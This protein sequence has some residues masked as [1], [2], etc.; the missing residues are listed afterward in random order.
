VTPLVRAKGGELGVRAAPFKGVQTSLALWRL[1]LDSELVFA[2]DAGTT[3]ASRPSRRTGIEWAT[4][5]KPSRAVTA[6][7]DLTVSRA[8]FTDFDP[9]GS[10]IPGATNRTASGGISYAEG[11]WSAGLRLRYFGP[12]ALI[13]DDSQRSGSSTLVNAKLGYAVAKQLKIGVEVLNVFNRKVDD[14]TYFYTS[15][16]PGEPAEGVADK[17]FHPAEPRSLRVSAVLQF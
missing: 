6:D 11:R 1:D 9:V 15:R 10:Y 14:I 12:R 16:L 7:F 3:E 17:H 5:Y 2:G 4:F 13:E 8:R